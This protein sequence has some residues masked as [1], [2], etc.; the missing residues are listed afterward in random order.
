VTRSA[1]HSVIKQELTIYDWAN[2]QIISPGQY[3]FPVSFMVP[4]GLPGSFFFMGGSTVAEIEYDV[5]A[6][7]KPERDNIPKLKHKRDVVVREHLQGN[8]QTKEVTITK[9]LKTWCC[10]DS[11]T[12]VMKTSFEK[13]A[14]APGEEARVI[15]EVDNSKS[16][17]CIMNTTFSLNQTLNLTAGAHHRNFG[18]NIRSLD[19]GGAQPGESFKGDSCKIGSI[20]L[21]PGQEGHS[22]DFRGENAEIV[23]TPLDPK[24][25]LTPS[26]HGK[27]VKSDFYLNVSCNVDG[28]LCCDVPPSTSLPIQ[29]YSAARMQVPDPQ[30][31]AN[32]QPKQMPTAN[33]TITIVQRADGGQDIHIQQGESPVQPSMPNSQMPQQNF[34]QPTQS[35]MPMNNNMGAPMMNNNMNSQMMNNNMGAPMMNN[36]MNNQMM[37]NNMGAPMMNNGMNNQM[38]NNQPCYQP[39]QQHQEKSAQP[40]LMMNNNMGAPMMNNGQP[41]YNPMPHEMNMNPQYM[42]QPGYTPGNYGM[43]QTMNP[44]QVQVGQNQQY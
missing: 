43:P 35:Q 31:P 1:K 10:I 27:L 4:Q 6:F 22:K 3:S 9:P 19:L 28:C 2:G 38:M 30:P 41:G 11:G 39:V 12:V 20:Q 25:V 36:N 32:W 29:I 37:N 23:D 15:T 42:N 18:F 7:L 44:Q 21:P 16:S 13:S 33:L 5:E 14:Y 24:M 34:G 17:L 40:Q 8:I 26:T